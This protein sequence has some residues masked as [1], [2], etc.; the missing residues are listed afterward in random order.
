M[1]WA[2]HKKKQYS[3]VDVSHVTMDEVA[4]AKHHRGL[5]IWDRCPQFMYRVDVQTDLCNAIY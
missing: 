3:V 4:R 5:G 2:G 1:Q